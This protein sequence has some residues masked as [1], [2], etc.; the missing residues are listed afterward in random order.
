MNI[1][2]GD[3]FLINWDPSQ[4]HE[5]QKFRPGV[6]VSSQV[7]LCNHS[8][9][10]VLP[11]TS[12]IKNCTEYDVFIKKTE[13]N[14]LFADSVIKVGYVSSFDPRRF[15]KKIGNAENNILEKSLKYLKEVH[16]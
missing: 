14:K 7:A 10:S 12:N 3:I 15:I 11:L 4:G 9:V 16:F 2:T 1:Q 13:E 5:F 6:V 8:L